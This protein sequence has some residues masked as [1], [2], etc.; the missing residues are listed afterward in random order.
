MR[1]TV[2]KAVELLSGGEIVALPT[3]TVYGLAAS[4]RNESALT[5]I[6]HEK[7]RPFFDPLIVH[8]S[9]F[10]MLS[11]LVRTVHPMERLL[12]NTFWPGPLT[13]VMDKASHLSSLITAGQPAVGVRWPAHP[14]AAEVIARVGCGLAAPSANR[15]GRVSPTSIE[16]VEAELPGVA[17][18]DGGPSE[19]GV[20]S[21]V[22]RLDDESKTVL[23]YRPGWITTEQLQE[24][25]Q[26]EEPSWRVNVASSPVAPGQ[27]Q[28]H[29]QP[30]TP[31]LWT[32][33]PSEITL[34][35]VVE[36]N[37]TGD[38]RVLV[39]SDDPR[40]AARS[41]YSELRS[42]DA[43]SPSLIVI[44]QLPGQFGGLWDAIWNRVDKA[45]SIY[46]LKGQLWHK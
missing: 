3:E 30:R 43:G 15:F 46:F 45:S 22:V 32:D 2:D 38:P 27:L 28:H 36:S 9:D 14:V 5:K 20:E 33:Q 35:R 23:I 19:C 37:L 41:L 17:V 34:S 18:V 24:F 25:V 11:E 26:S 42:L 13:L 8:I 44:Q 10:E 39:L 1:V 12:M 29:Y 40:L 16:H 31:V 7:R 4:I 6:F 21:T